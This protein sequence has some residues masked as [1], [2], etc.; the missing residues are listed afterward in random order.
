MIT[1]SRISKHYGARTVVD[2][3]GLTTVSADKIARAID[4]RLVTNTN[5]LRI[6][7]TWDN[8][9]DARALA[10]HVAEIFITQNVSSQNDPDGAQKARVS[11]LERAAGSSRMARTTAAMSPRTPRPLLLNTAATR[12]T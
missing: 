12:L 6:T 11:E 4:P 2:E 10:Q 1:V 3:V 9:Q 8:P 7:V 5:I